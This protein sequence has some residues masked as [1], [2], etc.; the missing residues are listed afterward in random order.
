L[1]AGIGLVHAKFAGADAADLA[2][3]VFDGEYGVGLMKEGNRGADGVVPAAA[4]TYIDTDNGSAPAFDVYSAR[5]LREGERHD[6]LLSVKASTNGA[7]VLV[8]RQRADPALEA[9]CRWSMQ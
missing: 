2:V 5:P 3:A 9:T 4:V 6:N 8:M 7:N 1:Q